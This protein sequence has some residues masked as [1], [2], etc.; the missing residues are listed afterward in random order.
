MKPITLGIAVLGVLGIL[1]VP[2]MAYDGV[3]SNIV[4]VNQ[5][6]HG[7]YHGPSHAPYHA[8]YHPAYHGAYYGGWNG[9]RVYYPQPLAIPIVSSPL[10]PDYTPM[11]PQPVY[12]PYYGYYPGASFYYS[13]PQLSI[14]V[15]Y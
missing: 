4:H 11:F 9:D 6:Y 3:H 14:G 1:S 2:L 7:A 12:Q 15:G 5:Y 8:N 13:S 10:F